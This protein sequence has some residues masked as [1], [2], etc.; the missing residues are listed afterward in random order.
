MCCPYFEGSVSPY[1]HHLHLHY[2]PLEASISINTLFMIFLYLSPTELADNPLTSV[3]LRE[4]RLVV[5]AAVSPHYKWGQWQTV[6]MY[7]VL[8]ERGTTPFVDRVSPTVLIHACL[9]FQEQVFVEWATCNHLV[10]EH[11]VFLSG[12]HMVAFKSWVLQVLLLLMWMY[13]LKEESLQFSIFKVSLLGALDHGSRWHESR[14][15]WLL[16]HYNPRSHV[17]L[18]VVSS[19]SVWKA[20]LLVFNAAQTL[21]HY[22]YYHIK[23]KDDC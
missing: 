14:S 21:S 5:M 12:L 17:L 4:S 2:C 13:A 19:P 6:A 22:F 3:M 20:A 8:R 7:R 16:S 15:G 11:C 23:A 1:S 18:W 10:S 9:P